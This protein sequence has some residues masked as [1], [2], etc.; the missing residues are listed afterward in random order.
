MRAAGGG[1]AIWFSKFY[2]LVCFANAHDHERADKMKNIILL[3]ALLSFATCAPK[4]P[5]FLT[6]VNSGIE[7]IKVSV[8]GRAFTINP[9][10]HITK[11]IS[12]GLHQI[13]INDGSSIS[14]PVALGKTTVFDS[15][16]LSCYAVADCAG[17]YSDGVH[18]II[19]K[20]KQKQVFTTKDTMFVYL[21]TYLPEKLEP[22]KSALRLQQVDCEIIDNDAELIETIGNLK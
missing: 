2:A 5:G 6:L 4:N 1:E 11:E 15:T 14:V 18:S 12:S 19:E 16:G 7:V 13:K 20:F 22:G 10:N 21:G 9:S 8:D 3:A 17:R